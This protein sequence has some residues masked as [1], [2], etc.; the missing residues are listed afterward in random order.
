MM[1]QYLM[2]LLGG[3]LGGRGG[4]HGPG[5]DPFAALLGLGGS[6]NGRWGD[7]AFSQ[8]ALDQI[9]SELM[10]NSNTHRPVPAPEE[11]VDKLPRELLEEGCELTPL[12]GTM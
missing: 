12:I 11:V 8:E 6:G 9:V 4:S 1:A 3:G 2:A 7:Y 5:L 10:E